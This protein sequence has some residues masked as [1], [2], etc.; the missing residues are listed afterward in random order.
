MEAI[1][2]SEK[3]TVFDIPCCPICGQPN[4]DGSGVVLIK[5]E[6]SYGLAHED[7]IQQLDDGG[8]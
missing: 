5:V 6:D 3:L 8:K 7:C 4:C 2:L 1:D